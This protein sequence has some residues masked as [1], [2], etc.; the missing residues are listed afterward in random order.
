[1]DLLTLNRNLHGLGVVND[2]LADTHASSLDSLLAHVEALLMADDRTILGDR[3]LLIS[4]GLSLGISG[5]FGIG[6]L[7]T[8]NTLVGVCI[9]GLRIRSE[10]VWVVT[11]KLVSLVL[12]EVTVGVNVRGVL[13]LVL[14]VGSADLVA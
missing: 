2:V 1:M 7:L 6:N 14:G 3:G 4:R 10:S 5:R 13:H 11:V 8:S 12:R 9:G